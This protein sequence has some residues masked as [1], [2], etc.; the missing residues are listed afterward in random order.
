MTQHAHLLALLE[1][2]YFHF[3]GVTRLVEGIYLTMGHIYH[4]FRRSHNNAVLSAH[5]LLNILNQAEAGCIPTGQVYGI[6]VSDFKD[7]RRF[8]ESPLWRLLTY[9]QRFR[10]IEWVRARF[11]LE[12]FGSW[13][14]G[15]PWNN[16][17]VDFGREVQRAWDK[18]LV[19]L[20]LPWV[21]T[22]RGVQRQDRTLQVPP[23]DPPQPPPSPPPPPPSPPPSAPPPP[24]PPPP[25][26]PPPPPS[27]PASSPPSPPP[28]GPP[29]PPRSPRA[30]HPPPSSPRQSPVPS[31]TTGLAL[32]AWP[33]VLERSEYTRGEGANAS[34]VMGDDCVVGDDCSVGG[35]WG[36]VSSSLGK[37]KRF[38]M[39]AAALALGSANNGAGPRQPFA[40][41]G[42]Y[43]AGGP[44]LSACCGVFQRAHGV[45]AHDR[46]YVEH[47]PIC[48]GGRCGRCWTGLPSWRAAPCEC[49]HIPPTL[50]ELLPDGV[51]DGESTDDEVV[52]DVNVPTPPLMATHVVSS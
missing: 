25:T 52:L 10:L 1:D 21:W 47:C 26:P 3:Y 14:M 7:L 40:H 29:S 20:R 50:G 24:S 8:T 32:H 41:G 6:D 23:K 19:S 42:R 33:H 46:A 36:V 17:Y 12:A 44:W 48:Q 4:G 35:V 38:L 27:P 18:F 2:Q 39:H 15:F 43:E 9:E 37:Q 22:G 51:D 11:N 31:H 34:G 30:P 45:P 5:D 49:G 28:P 13:N 16:G